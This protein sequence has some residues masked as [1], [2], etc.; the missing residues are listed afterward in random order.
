MKSL[1]LMM[2]FLTKLPLPFEIKADKEDFSK[3]VIW[4]PVVGAIIGLMLSGLFWISNKYFNPLLAAATVV[5]FEVFIT[6]GLHLDGLADS[7][8]GLYSYRDKEKMLEIMKD[9]RVGT[10]GVLAIVFVI[11]L[12]IALIY[13][14]DES[15]ALVI[16]CL[17]PIVSRLMLV[18]LAGFSKYA[19]EKG[20]GGF[21]I[22]ETSAKQVIAA[23]TLTLILHGIYPLG[24]ILLIPMIVITFIYRYHVYSKIDGLTG[25]ILGSWV[26][27]GEVIYLIMFLLILR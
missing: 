24:L 2:Q 15:K 7:F 21:F 19:R 25:D 5:C 12:K 18:I 22:G 26:E 13:S 23:V 1:I 17:M 3:G 8:D 27:Q 9:S 6:G 11:I 20:M 16:L 4:F 10:N 14:L